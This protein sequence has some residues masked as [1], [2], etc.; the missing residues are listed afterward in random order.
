MLLADLGAEVIKIERPPEGDGARNWPNFGPSIFL[1]LN[2]NKKSLALNLTKKSGKEAF[3]RLVRRADIVVEN[4]SPGVVEKL[5]A[6]YELVK[7]LNPNITYC[8]ISG[9]GKFTAYSDFPAW[10]PVIQAM[11]G[12]MSV[13]GEKNGAPV[14][15]GAAVV[16]MG[17]G[18]YGA[19]GI[20]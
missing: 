3:Q 12:L 18:L 11:S 20:L 5:G 2:R 16:D 13:T 9:Y 19:L 7:S 14:R 15:I 1:A 4:L 6:S 8:S 17:A 10:D